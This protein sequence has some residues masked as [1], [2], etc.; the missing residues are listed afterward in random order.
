VSAEP[1]GLFVAFSRDDQLASADVRSPTAATILSLTLS[2][3]L[4]L[5]TTR[6]PHGY[7]TGDTVNMRVGGWHGTTLMRHP[8]N[9]AW[10]ITVVSPTTFTLNGSATPVGHVF[11]H[12]FVYKTLVDARPEMT[13]LLNWLAS[14]GGGRLELP[15]GTLAIASSDTTVGTGT[16]V[17]I[18]SNVHIHGQG[19]GHSNIVCADNLNKFVLQSIGTSNWKFSDFTIYGNRGYMGVGGYHAIRA[20]SPD[21]ITEYGILENL[22]ILGSAGY[23]I[24]YQSEGSFQHMR[25]DRVRI[26]ESDSDGL[27]FKNRL[28]RND[29]LVFNNVE[30]TDFGLGQIGTAAATTKTLGANPIATTSGSPTVT[31]TETSHGRLT[32]QVVT[33]TGAAS[34]GG[35]TINGSHTMQVVSANA[36]SY[37]ASSNA[38]STATGGG[39][40]V[41]VQSPFYSSGDAGIDIRGPAQVRDP[42]IMLSFPGSCAI[43]LRF[44]EPGGGNGEGANR[45][46]LTGARVRM[47]PGANPIGTI[48]LAVYSDDTAVSSFSVQDTNVGV[49][50][51][52][53]AD[54]T[55]IG[56]G[57]VANNGTYG[58]WI[59]GENVAVSGVRAR[60]CGTSFYVHG[61]V[62]T[63][64]GGYPPDPFTTTSG[65]AVVAV[66][67]PAHGHANGDSVTIY[68]AALFN[69]VDL[70][71]VYVI[72]GVTTNSYTVTA[73]TTAN[74]SGS[75]GGADVS[76]SWVG[77]IHL[78]KGIKLVGC[79][80]EGATVVGYQLGSRSLGTTITSCHSDDTDLAG[81]VDADPRSRVGPGNTGKLPNKEPVIALPTDG[82]PTVLTVADLGV[83]Y[84]L[85]SNATVKAPITFPAITTHMVGSSV[86]IALNAAIGVR[87]IPNGA[88]IRV[89]GAATGATTLAI[90]STTNGAAVTF[91]AVTTSVWEAEAVVGT[92]TQVA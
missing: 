36:W 86:R 20:G 66:S 92:W 78:T 58:M 39:S 38:S 45:S 79:G 47:R 54:N 51:Q 53:S 5:V 16:A 68:D 4:T 22:E 29:D 87:L 6:R 26:C 44:G 71:G 91:R 8:A 90:E 82:T 69:N 17:S 35:L 72:A 24:G 30:V 80:S 81:L 62:I 21:Y 32:G 67:H 77:N 3:A 1:S 52:A 64:E 50:V 31:V 55:S 46:T 56:S 49:L 88:A 33:I 73:H 15:F 57:S 48:G 2:G 61:E 25:L 14:E 18:P 34:V 28:D 76:W 41:V 7:V 40:A 19:I 63:E 83:T 11:L 85:Q 60:D 42:N 37:Q 27:D 65:S 13:R 23:G 10:T 43:R 59:Q 75:G 89:L 12:G 70:D 74:A 9:G 84:N